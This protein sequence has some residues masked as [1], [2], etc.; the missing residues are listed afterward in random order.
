M[1]EPLRLYPT[2]MEAQDAVLNH[3]L[4]YLR[5]VQQESIGCLMHC[6]FTVGDYAATFLPH[7]HRMTTTT[8]CPAKE[9]AALV[10]ESAFATD[11]GSRTAAKAIPW[12]LILT[13][14]AD[15]LKRWL[16][17]R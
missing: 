5:G 10:L 11:P 13:I 7:D 2:F 17:G 6:A 15:L 1:S 12:I 16:E 8:A 3:L 14:A 9:E 4:P